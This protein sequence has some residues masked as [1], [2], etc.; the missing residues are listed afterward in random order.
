MRSNRLTTD[1]QTS[2]ALRRLA[3]AASPLI[4]ALAAGPALAQ[5]EAETEST[6]LPTVVVTASGGAVE[7]EDAPATIT[8]VTAEEIAKMGASDVRQVLSRIEGITLGRSGNQTTVQIR[9]MSERYTL[10]LVDGKRVS[11]APNLFR[12]NDYD[13]GW[14]PVDAIERIE[15]IHGPMSTLYGSDAM[16]GVVNIIT[17]KAT[18]KWSG[19]FTAD[20]TAQ[21]NR[22]AG[23]EASAGFFISGPLIEDKLSLKI[24]GGWDR[25][26]ADDPT[27]NPTP[28]LAGFGEDDDRYADATLTWFADADNEFSLNYGFSRRDHSDFPL[29]RHALSLGH[30]GTYDFGETDLQL[31]GDRI[32]NEYGHGNVA[33]V[34]QPNTAYNAGVDGKLVMPVTLGLDQTVTLGA[35]HRYQRIEDEFVLTGG[36]DTTSSVSQSAIFVEDEI[37]VTEDF[38]VTLG[39]RGDF[40]ENFGS[41]FSPRIY[42]VFHV[43][44]NVTLRGGWSTAF[45]AP[46]LLENSPNWLQISC[47]GGCF[48]VGSDDLD[49]ETSQTV[50]IGVSYADALWSGAVT[51]FRND[52]EDMIPFPP[53]RTGDP[54]LAT[55]FSNFVGLD[56]LGRPIFSYENI[57]EARTQGIEANVSVRP[58]ETLTIS[59]NYTYLDAEAQS[60]VKRPLIY[61]PEHSANLALDWQAT[62]A[63]D[64]SVAVN[65]VGEQYTSVP[66][67]GNL[68]NAT[69]VDSFVTSDVIA[70][71][72][73]NDHLTV[74]AGVLNIADKTVTRTIGNDFNVDGRRFFLST[75]ASF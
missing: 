74:R 69:T 19:S 48:L 22:D 9:G 60:G 46:T 6:V 40:H 14:V 55:T 64:L 63:L 42:G 26:N 27:L 2:R 66:T 7:L 50:E 45:K 75:T 28:T 5:T 37:A 31:W 49:P 24:F 57:D 12:G 13:S 4:L 71:Y 72:D 68:A 38:L 11:S 30:R 17:K 8:V 47:G 20:Y 52:I 41:H 16:G 43:T 1:A 34:D 21:E 36:G 3:A 67:N 33:G 65:Y 35:S 25:R 32:H 61:Q 23:D 39:G 73:V 58:T 62:E 15:V 70:S 56:S 44:D 54:V 51:L 59:A 29:E 18:G 10:F 53:A